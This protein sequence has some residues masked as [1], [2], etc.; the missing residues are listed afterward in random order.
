MDNLGRNSILT[1]ALVNRHED[2]EEMNK[3]DLIGTT[4][5]QSGQGKKSYN[6]VPGMPYKMHPLGPMEF[7]TLYGERAQN[8][9]KAE[10]PSGEVLLM[11]TTPKNPELIIKMVIIF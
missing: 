9:N 4:N 6:L 11:L 10:V 2:Q 8:G 1:A 7:S 3:I 5:Q